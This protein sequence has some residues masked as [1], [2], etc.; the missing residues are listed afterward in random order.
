MVTDT[1]IETTEAER[2]AAYQRGWNDAA[3]G[4]EPISV[5]PIMYAIGYKDCKTGTPA[6]YEVKS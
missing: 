5:F 2:I 4:R 3:R 6:R 1:L